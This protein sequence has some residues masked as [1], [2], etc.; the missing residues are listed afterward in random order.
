MSYRKR[1]PR[2]RG[3]AHIGFC[4]PIT[5]TRTRLIMRSACAGRAVVFAALKIKPRSAPHPTDSPSIPQSPT[6][7]NTPSDRGLATRRRS[8]QWANGRG[9]HPQSP[10][11]AARRRPLGRCSERPPPPGTQPRFRQSARSARSNCRARLNRAALLAQ[12]PHAR[13][14]R[15]RRLAPAP[16]PS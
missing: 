11:N 13:I 14:H 9:A 16:T 3:L 10:P 6:A 15:T 5:S 7:A 2:A 12:R 8:R 1:C 4:T